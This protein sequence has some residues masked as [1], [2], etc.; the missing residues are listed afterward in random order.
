VS[1]YLADAANCCIDL[2][3]LTAFRRY[4]RDLRV[5]FNLSFEA[6]DQVTRLVVTKGHITNPWRRRTRT[7]KLTWPSVAALLQVHAA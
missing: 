5:R 3:L 4:L 6:A 7:L 2:P 1:S